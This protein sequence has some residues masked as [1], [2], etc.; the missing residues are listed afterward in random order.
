MK[1]WIAITV[2]LILT[3]TN[4]VMRKRLSVLENLLSLMVIEF[5]ATSYFAILVVNL[6]VWKID[7]QMNNYIIFLLFEVIV[8]PVLIL[9]FYN[10]FLVASKLN[11]LLL[12]ILK[13]SI[14]CAIEYLLVH[15]GVITFQGWQYWQSF[16]G[17]LIMMCLGGLLLIAF[18]IV[19]LREGNN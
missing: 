1:L 5:I 9:I 4:I 19:T 17:Y 8:A 6:S 15:S 16:L 10:V 14:L 3:I 11:K 2:C 12:M 13:V 18:R 7:Q